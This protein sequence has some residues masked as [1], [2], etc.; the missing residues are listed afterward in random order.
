MKIWDI[1]EDTR[2]K[3]KSRV[4]AALMTQKLFNVYQILTLHIK[5]FI[6][7]LVK[8]YAINAWKSQAVRCGKYLEKGKTWKWSGISNS[9][10]AT[11]LLTIIHSY[12]NSLSRKDKN[13]KEKRNLHSHLPYLRF[14]CSDVTG[15]WK[16]YWSAFV[17]DIHQNIY[18]RK[19][20]EKGT[21]LHFAIKKN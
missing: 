18:A 17:K 14:Y 8:S 16:Y 21:L 11:K 3:Y 20:R 4:E 1:Q 9:L 13:Q 12:S 5:T 7:R 19:K 6:P 10:L 2:M 15:N